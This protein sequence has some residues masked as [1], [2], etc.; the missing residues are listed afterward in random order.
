MV[1][2]F[3]MRTLELKRN[4]HHL[5]DTIEDESVLEAIATLLSREAGSPVDF[6]DGLSPAQQAQI[7]EGRRDIAAGRKKPFSE[8]LKKY[9]Q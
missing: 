5:I 7:D 8:I 3:K 6:W 2:Q 9:A 1:S 4:L